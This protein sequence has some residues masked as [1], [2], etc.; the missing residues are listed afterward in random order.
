MPEISHPSAP[1]RCEFCRR[2]KLPFERALAYGPY[3]GALRG[4][5]HLLKYEGVE[6]AADALGQRLACVIQSLLAE[7]KD[8][9]L[10]VPVPLYRSKQ[11]ERRFNQSEAI[12]RSALR[13]LPAKEST[14]LS[15]AHDALR[16]VRET[17][18]QT[19]LTRHQRRQNMRG[20]FAVTDATRVR[21]RV[22]LL[23]DDVMTTG[24]TV[25][26]CARVL[27]RSGAKSVYVGTVARVLRGEQV[28]AGLR[29]TARAAEAN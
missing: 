20:A 7:T 22:I 18:S 4:L 28:S 8:E 11:R 21:D 13:R 24:T 17:R 27:K 25:A 12:A 23:I 6:T 2:A 10:V 14:R 29:P 9:L 1:D 26:E 16:R 15:I 3:E 19:G 5:V